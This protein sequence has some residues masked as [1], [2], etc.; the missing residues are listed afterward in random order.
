MNQITVD[1]VES[2]ANSLKAHAK[3]IMQFTRACEPETNDELHCRLKS[4]EFLKT[5]KEISGLESPKLELEL[6]YNS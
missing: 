3:P 1:K 2:N 4:E 5:S 6:I